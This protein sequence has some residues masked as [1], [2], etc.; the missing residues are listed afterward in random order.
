MIQGISE[1]NQPRGIY[2]EFN[3]MIAERINPRSSMHVKSAVKL[4]DLEEVVRTVQQ[5]IH[6][7]GQF[8]TYDASGKMV[9]FGSLGDGIDVYA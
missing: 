2:E 1:R 7:I 5:A 3:R 6:V 8:S 9:A 4:C